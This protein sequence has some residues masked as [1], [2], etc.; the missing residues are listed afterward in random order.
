[1]G[2]GGALGPDL[3]PVTPLPFVW[4]LVTS[5]F[6]SRG[7]RGANSHPPLRGRRGTYG[8]PWFCVAGV[9]LVGLGGALG[10]D[11]SPVTPLPFGGRR[12][13]W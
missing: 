6:I 4:H 11:L 1:M 10:P 3:S 7:R 12:G 8:I 13:T 9:A 5:T 2:L